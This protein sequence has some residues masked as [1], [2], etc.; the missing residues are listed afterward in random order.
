MSNNYVQIVILI[1]V[2]AASNQIIF[3]KW[4][5]VP[6]PAGQRTT[7]HTPAQIPQAEQSIIV[8]RTLPNTFI[9][10][11]GTAPLTLEFHKLF[12]R[13]PVG[14]EHDRLWARG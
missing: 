1:A 13:L 4:V 12:L 2:K 14:G 8:T 9:I 10:T 11:A 7:R 3:E 5:L 6:I